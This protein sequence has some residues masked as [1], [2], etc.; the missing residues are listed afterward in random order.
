MPDIQNRKTKNS[1][2]MLHDRLEEIAD[3]CEKEVDD[4]YAFWLA[5]EAGIPASDH[6]Q[7]CVIGNVKLSIRVLTGYLLFT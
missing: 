4:D 7:H 3:L 2:E 6:W 1:F 5:A